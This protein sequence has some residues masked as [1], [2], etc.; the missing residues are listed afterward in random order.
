MSTRKTVAD[1]AP[2]ST[3]AIAATAAPRMPPRS[4]RSTVLAAFSRREGLGVAAVAASV[5]IA[6]LTIPLVRNVS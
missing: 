5:V 6:H 2:A 3:H 4:A 1:S